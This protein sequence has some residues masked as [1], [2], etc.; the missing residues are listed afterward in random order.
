MQRLGQDRRLNGGKTM[1]ILP[2]VLKPNLKIVFCGMAADARSAKLKVYYAE[3][4]NNF[5]SMLYKVGLTP[6]KLKPREF[7]QLVA[8]DLGLTNLVKDK[9]GIDASIHPTQQDIMKLRD[10]LKLYKPKVLAFTGKGSANCFLRDYADWHYVD[11]HHID[12][13]YVDYGVQKESIGQTK[14]YVLP[15][16][17]VQA[18]EDGEKY[19]RELAQSINVR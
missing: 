19:W 17:K 2:D 13:H 12:W 11:P 5:W 15:S 8:Y 1:D 16:T 7:G 6:C 3:I 9:S 10:K 4:G 14:I 18:N